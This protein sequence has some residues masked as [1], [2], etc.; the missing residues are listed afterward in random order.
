MAL[1]ARSDWQRHLKLA[2]EELQFEGIRGHGLLDDDMSTMMGKGEYSFVNVDIVMDYLVELEMKPIVELSFTPSS[3][4]SCGQQ[5]K[6]TLVQ[7][8]CTIIFL[9]C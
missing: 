2:R 4:V 9:V 6:I 7:T 3:L 5:V 1:G 8:C